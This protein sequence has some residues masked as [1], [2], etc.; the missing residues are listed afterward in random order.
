MNFIDFVQFVKTNSV[1]ETIYEDTEDRL[2]LVIGMLDAYALTNKLV[3]AERKEMQAKIETLHA[4]YEL[5]TKQ[6][7]YLMDQQSA[8]V[9][10][11]RGRV[12]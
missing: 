6:R 9:A 5:A 12:Q 11:M 8:Q 7:D 4:M 2:I 3:E 10:A 1:Y